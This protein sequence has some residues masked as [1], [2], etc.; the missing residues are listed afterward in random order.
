MASFSFTNALVPVVIGAN[1]FTNGLVF[2]SRVYSPLSAVPPVLATDSGATGMQHMGVLKDFMIAGP[3]TNL[4][5]IPPPFLIMSSVDVIRWIGVSNL[6]YTVQ[7]NTNLASTNWLTLGTAI[8]TS[9]NLSFT[10]SSVG[11]PQRFYRVTYP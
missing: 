7:A 5:S 1:A 11:T 2:D 6:A 8:S 3:V 10:N 4:V 9:T